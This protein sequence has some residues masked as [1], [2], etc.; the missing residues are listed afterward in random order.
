[1]GTCA[2]GPSG[3]DLIPKTLAQGEHNGYRFVVAGIP[4]GFAATAVPVAFGSTGRRTFFMDQSKSVKQNW[5]QEPANAL[6][7]EFR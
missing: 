2:G 5:S 1:M 6:S 7:E 4:G 3:A